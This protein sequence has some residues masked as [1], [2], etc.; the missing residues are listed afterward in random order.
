MKIYYIPTSTLNFNNIFSTESISPKSFYEK[1]GFGYGRWQSVEENNFEDIIVL[2]D[3][4][5]VFSRPKS[6]LEDH[7]MLIEIRT[8]ESFDKIQDGVYK[9][10]RTIYLDP[11]NTRI[12]FF[13]EDDKRIALINSESSG[14]TKM[15]RLYEKK[16]EIENNYKG[17]F[18]VINENF[19]RN[20][21]QKEKLINEDRKINKLKGLLYGYYI[22][23]FLSSSADKVEKLSILTDVNNIFNSILSNPRRIPSEIQRRRL[24]SLFEKLLSYSP[25]V[26]A[27]N[28]NL[29]RE[30]AA[31]IVQATL[32]EFGADLP[33]LFPA[34]SEL[35]DCLQ[36]MPE[37]KQFATSSNTDYKFINPAIEWINKEI[38]NSQDEIRKSHQ[39]LSIDNIEIIVSKEGLFSIDYIK[40]EVLTKLYISCV[41]DIFSS[42]R[43][44]GKICTFKVDLAKEITYKA[45]DICGDNWTQNPLRSYLNQLIRHL[46]GEEFTQSWDNE[47]LSSIAAVLIKGD[48]WETL[49]QFMQSKGM[50]DYRLAF[51][52]YGV[53]NGFANLTR[54]FTDNLISLERKYVWD[55][56]REFYGEIFQKPLTSKEVEDDAIREVIFPSEEADRAY[57]HNYRYQSGNNARVYMQTGVIEERIS[58]E[59]RNQVKEFFNQTD[60]FKNKKALE[61]ALDEVLG[62]C[63]SL[64]A[65]LDE[66]GQCARWQTE[67]KKPSKALKIMRDQF[68]GQKSML[69]NT[70]NYGTL[71]RDHSWIEKCSQF[72]STDEARKGFIN[73]GNYLIDNYTRRNGR[74]KYDNK[75]NKSVIEHFIEKLIPSYYAS[76]QMKYLVEEMNLHKVR[77]YLE[78][79][80]GD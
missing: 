16:L 21:S 4:P 65:A 78:Q 58:E 22:G 8:D 64:K 10:E 70:S 69:E 52:I 35:L 63:P 77:E 56:Y 54:D 42:S 28:K 62:R 26:K 27:L 19:D 75:D 18:P 80:Y 59:V 14:E 5:H 15:I 34:L 50:Y 24:E 57:A 3:K 46:A 31:A 13:S 17:M 61:P 20:S 32:K 23:A 43:Y 36:K 67:S 41:N 12:I 73:R 66:L 60:K 7:P 25:L 9:S 68:L 2:Y 51:S 37:E 6:D 1:R 71:L 48:S 55:I 79:H 76:A 45:K 49:L 38:S 29:E 53:L 30:D 33:Q 72:S 47:L 44:D 74:Y 40:E 39:P 11:W